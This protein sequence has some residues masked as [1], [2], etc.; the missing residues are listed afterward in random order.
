VL[1]ADRKWFTRV[2]AA[3]VIAETLIDID[4]QYPGPDPDARQE[5]LRAKT[6]LESEVAREAATAPTPASAARS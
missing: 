3:A 5:L 2:C 4:P 1:P 6:E